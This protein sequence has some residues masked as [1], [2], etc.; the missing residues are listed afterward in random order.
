MWLHHGMVDEIKM[1]SWI[2]GETLCRNTKRYC[3]DVYLGDC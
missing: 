3:E 2:H 1:R